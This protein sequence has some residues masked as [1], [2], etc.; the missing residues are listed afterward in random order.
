MAVAVEVPGN[1]KAKLTTSVATFPMFT[2]TKQNFKLLNIQ[3]EKVY[4]SS[5]LS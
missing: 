5:D 2:Y 3:T 1:A 4:R